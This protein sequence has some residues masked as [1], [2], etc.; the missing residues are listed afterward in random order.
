MKKKKSLSPL[1]IFRG[2]R[3]REG[4]KEKGHVLYLG[5]IGTSFLQ[6]DEDKEG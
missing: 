4:N 2:R 5:I 6:R 3:G 1:A